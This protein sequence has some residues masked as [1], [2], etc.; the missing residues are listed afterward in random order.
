M[1]EKGYEIFENKLLNLLKM[2][3]DIY[4]ELCGQYPF[5]LVG[6]DK[7]KPTHTVIEGFIAKH[8]KSLRM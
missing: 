2:N 4:K 3:A 1:R 8:I 7:E 6:Y 5:Y